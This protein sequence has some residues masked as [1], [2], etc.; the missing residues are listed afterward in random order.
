MNP[1]VA[2]KG[3]V[4]GKLRGGF[5]KGLRNEEVTKRFKNGCNPL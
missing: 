5:S 3:A 4:S 1:P 2:S